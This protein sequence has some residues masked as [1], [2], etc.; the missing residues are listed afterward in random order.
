MSENQV[1]LIGF[2]LV[3]DLVFEYEILE[4][5]EL[6]KVC[7]LETI[8][9]F[10][11]KGDKA[12]P[13]SYFGS[14]KLI[15]LKELIE[16]L[17]VKTIVC[18]DEL[19][20]AQQEHLQEALGCQ[21]IDRTMLILEIFSQKAHTKE[22]KLQVEISALQY[23]LP[24][25]R[26]SFV[27]L[28]RQG[29][30]YGFRNRGSGETKLELSRR[31]VERRVA[32]CKEELK[33]LVLQ[34]QTQ[35][36]QRQNSTIK[37][38]AVVGYTNAGKSTLI[39]SLVS[40]KDKEVF[41]KDQLFATLETRVRQVELAQHF[42]CL[43][44]DTVGF[45]DKLP[46]QLIKAFRSTLEEIKEVDLLLHVIDISNPYHSKQEAI[47]LKVLSEIGVE[48]IPLINVYN[49]IDKTELDYKAG[50]NKI[51][52][53]AINNQG[54]DLLKQMIIDKLYLDYETVQ[55]L[56]PYTMTSQVSEI[57]NYYATLG[58]NEIETGIE[59]AVLIPKMLKEKYKDYLINKS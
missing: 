38:V 12:H 30:G 31:L 28:S 17:E 35:R 7:G 15:E 56:F 57:R 25:L 13:H 4:L 48:N 8:K 39:N 37:S 40:S 58:Y 32:T 53:S 42:H 47:T 20:P 3:D 11:Q 52:L 27:G 10:A 2:Q 5:E 50:E 9:V 41:V 19:S 55:F 34:R 43:I 33:E 21:I 14:G 24:R 22:A 23:A 18:N 59:I 49:K 54:I 45:V 51:F 26:G 29:G 16:E 6:A 46:H 44:S 1:I 36:K